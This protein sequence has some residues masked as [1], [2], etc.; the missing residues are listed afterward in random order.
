MK[1]LL[2]F[3][4]PFYNVEKYIAQCLD[5]V[6]QQ[7]IP[8]EDYEVICVNDA[9][10]DHSRDIVLEYQK[11][12]TNLILVE[13]EVNKKLGAARNT[14]RKIARGKYVWNVDSDDMVEP[15][16]LGEIIK[17]CETN[18][19]DV[20]VFRHRHL[21]GE[22]ILD[23]DK[24]TWNEMSEP[25]SGFN[26]W[27][28]QCLDKPGIICPVWNKIFRKDYL[29][30]NGIFSPEINMGED[31]PFSIE[32]VLLAEKVSVINDK[33]YIHRENPD[34]LAHSLRKMPSPKTLYENSFVCGKYIHKLVKRIPREE[35]LIITSVISVEKYTI[36]LFFTFLND[37]TKTD[38][39]DFRKLCKKNLFSNLFVLKVFDII[40]TLKYFD[41]LL[42]G[43]RK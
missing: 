3:V 40:W 24:N 43:L 41:F 20:L 30:G 22:E 38:V 2:S 1:P 4:I 15:N 11:K 28:S 42:F 33:Y 17:Q 36:K 39:E 6:Y 23:N 10:P 7:D 37:M 14:G 18:E 32:A 29:N 27:K 13:H 19:L 5:S 8:E 26:F 16:C 9:S 25:V 35:T 34:S 12:H 31:V 21:R